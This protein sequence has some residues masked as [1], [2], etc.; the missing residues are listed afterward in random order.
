MQCRAQPYPQAF[1]L[2]RQNDPVRVTAYC[3]LRSDVRLEASL[4][5]V[6]RT[7]AFPPSL[8]LRNARVAGTCGR[9]LEAAQSR[10]VRSGQQVIDG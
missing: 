6:N 1:R 2:R 4:D 8:A 7:G 10:S 5:A 3:D 9:Y